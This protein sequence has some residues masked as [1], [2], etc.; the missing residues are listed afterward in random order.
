MNCGLRCS[1]LRIMGITLLHAAMDIS[2]RHPEPAADS[3]LAMWCKWQVHAHLAVTDASRTPCWLD[4]IH[5][6]S[7]VRLLQAGAVC[8][9]YLAVKVASKAS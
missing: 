8:K 9:P 4:A 3:A 5:Q 2:Q 1:Y 7:L 6:A